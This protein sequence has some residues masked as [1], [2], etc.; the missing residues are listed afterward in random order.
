MTRQRKF[1]LLLV[2]LLAM[3]SCRG[4]EDAEVIPSASDIE[5]DLSLGNVARILSSLPLEHDHLSE[6]HDAVNSSF[7][8][9]YDEEYMMSDLFENPGAGVGSNGVATKA[10]GYACPLRHLFEDYFESMPKTKAG[11][12]AKAYI[13]AL[14]SSDMQIYWPYS[15]EWDGEQYPIVTFDPGYGAESNYGYEIKLVDGGVRVVDSVYVDEA[16]AMQRPVWVINRNDDSAYS[17]MELITRGM[18]T[19]AEGS[20][21]GKTLKIKSFTMFRNYDSW[22]GGGSE[23]SMLT[24]KFPVVLCQKMPLCINTRGLLA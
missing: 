2:A 23:F 24:I 14:S 8:N 20:E 7:G 19:K 21:N 13:E 17:P 18:P 9:G 11:T 22:F 4:T 16:I 15:D 6:V 5:A 12:S 10:D 3:A 1:H